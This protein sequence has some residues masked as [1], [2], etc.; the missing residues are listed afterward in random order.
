MIEFLHR[1]AFSLYFRLKTLKGE[2]N[3]RRA[4]FTRSDFLSIP[5]RPD[6]I[7]LFLVVRNEELRLPYFFKYYRELGVDRFFVVDNAST[8]GTARF[9]L[10]QNNTHVFRTTQSYGKFNCG[11]TW[12]VSLLNRYGRGRWCLVVDADE[13][14]YYPDCEQA[15]LKDLARFLDEKGYGAIPS[16]LLEMYPRGPLSGADYRQGEDFLST[17]RYFDGDPIDIYKGDLYGGMRQRVFGVHPN[18]LKFVFLKYTKPVA[19]KQGC[20]IVKRARIADGISGCLLHFKYFSDFV[21]R[22][23]EEARREEHWNNAVEYKRYSE[24]FKKD[25][26]R[27]MYFHGSEEFRGS[28][29]LVNLGFMADNRG[30]SG[31]REKA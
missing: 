29:Q 23:E 16:F 9:L 31:L 28:A 15:S 5:D 20:H 27:S 2:L 1:I 13:I 26:G 11:H 4:V 25:P 22:C 12:L 18:L 6:E 21:F 17:A 24:V 14:F 30:F 10:S 7:R 3:F 8:D 19:L